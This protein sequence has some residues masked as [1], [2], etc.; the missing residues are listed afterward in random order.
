MKYKLF[1]FFLFFKTL[2]FCQSDIYYFKDSQ[3]T[4][5]IDDIRDKEFLLLNNKSLK[6]KE[7]VTY[8]FKILPTNSE[9]HF[10]F[11]I[12]DIIFNEA[13]F[14]Q[15]S[16]KV[17]NYPNERYLT[18]RFLRDKTSYIKTKSSRLS[19]LEVHLLKGND[20]IKNG[21]KDF[22]FIGLYYGIALLIIV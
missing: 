19:S 5:T 4:L 20:F 18:Y 22:L 10:F 17:L 3:S 21:K 6:H 7:N 16:E 15:N 11:Q 2:V 12:Q 1:L 13:V 9:S 8:W 14:Y